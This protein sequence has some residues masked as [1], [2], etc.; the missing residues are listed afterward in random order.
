MISVI[1]L[2]VLAIPLWI[3]VGF[4]T[5]IVPKSLFIVS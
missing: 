1:L 3:V 2:I 4:F 5:R